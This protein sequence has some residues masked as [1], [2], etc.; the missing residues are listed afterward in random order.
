MIWGVGDSEKFL[1]NSESSDFRLLGRWMQSN[2]GAGLGGVGGGQKGG[3][4]GT[5]NR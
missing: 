4:K 1:H 3:S 2:T 5:I